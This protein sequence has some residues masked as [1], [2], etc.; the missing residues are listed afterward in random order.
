MDKRYSPCLQM[1]RMIPFSKFV[2][3]SSVLESWE[4]TCDVREYV[5]CALFVLAFLFVEETHYKRVLP[6]SPTPSSPSSQSAEGKEMNTASHVENHSVVLPERKTFIQTLKLFHGIDRDAEFFMTMIR[7]FTYFTVPAVFW[8]ISTYGIYIGLGALAF[9]YTFPIKI[10]QPPYNWRVENTGLISVA[11]ATGY[12]LA[13]PFTFTS[14]RLAA[15]LTRRNNGIREA[16]MR[17][18]VLLPAMII[19]PAGLILYGLT[20]EYNLHFMGY[21][22]GVAM[23]NWGAYFYFSFTLAYAFWDGR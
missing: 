6:S 16:E 9:N 11:N 3:C 14:D 23:V 18:P 8:V 2:S 22:V 20:A 1:I 12:I 15:Y 10:Q 7:P 19:A 4:E 13:I 21:M 5:M 17:L